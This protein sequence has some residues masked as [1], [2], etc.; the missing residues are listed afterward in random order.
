MECPICENK[1]K[2]VD[3]RP[4]SGIRYRK[5]RCDA[6]GETFWT[7]EHIC[8]NDDLK[9]VREMLSSIRM[10]ERDDNKCKD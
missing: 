5:R 8:S 7:V 1:T 3:S 9:D 10:R 6:C 2:T 4:W